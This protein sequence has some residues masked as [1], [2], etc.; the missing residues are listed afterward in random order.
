[1]AEGWLRHL[2]PDDFE[3]YSAGIEAHGLN[4]YAIQVMAEAGIDIHQQRS[5]TVDQLPESHFEYVITVC[6]HANDVCP[7]FPAK[8][9]FIHHSF[10]DPPKLAA[11]ASNKEEALSCYQKVC[12]DIKQFVQKIDL[13]LI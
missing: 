4:P 5:Q 10:E 6:D 9:K 8:T 7:A 2:R 12:E 11:K 13:I 1:M 3:V